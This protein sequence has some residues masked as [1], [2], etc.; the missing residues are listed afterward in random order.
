MKADIGHRWLL[1]LTIAAASCSMPRVHYYTLEIPHSSPAAAAVV[2]S[3]INVQRFR[4]DTAL[5]DDRVLY[6]VNLN[7]LN[8]YEYHRWASPPV[9]LVTDYFIHR[10]KDSR[11]YAGVSS[12]KDYP[13]S[14]YTLQGVIHRFEE[15][16]HGKEVSA[17]VALELELVEAK[18]RVSVWRGEAECSRPLETRDMGGVVR[19]IH[20]CLDQTATTLLANMHAQMEKVKQ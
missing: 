8:F 3:R 11:T 18:T 4:A 15:V 9:D 2:G 17:A 19:G 20:A 5:S 12:Y 7:E 14:D 16:D 10:L 13:S 6:R 1:A